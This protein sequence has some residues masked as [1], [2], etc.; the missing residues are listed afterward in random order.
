VRE[1]CITPSFARLT[2][3]VTN[4]QFARETE[5]LKANLLLNGMILAELQNIRLSKTRQCQKEF[6]AVDQ[7][8]MM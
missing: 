5:H 7:A 3:L 2:A 8:A 1:N 6:F 4:A